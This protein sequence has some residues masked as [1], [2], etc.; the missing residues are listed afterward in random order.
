[1]SYEMNECDCSEYE[2][3]LNA[4]G[5]EALGAFNV[6]DRIER[7]AESG[8]VD[9]NDIDRLRYLLNRIL[10]YADMHGC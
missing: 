8:E 5:Y 2:E 4:I 9:L 7:D 6:L 3:C 1:M 10:D